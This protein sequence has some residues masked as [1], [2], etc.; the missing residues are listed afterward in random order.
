MPLIRKDLASLAGSFPRP[1]ECLQPTTF[2]DFGDSRVH[3]RTTLWV[4]DREDAREK[5]VALYLRIRDSYRYDPY[6]ISL[7]PADYRAS[8]LVGLDRTFCVPKAIL[9]AAMA[10]SAGV[11]AA[12]GFADVKNHLATERLLTTMRTDVFAFHGY[13]A[14]FIDGYWVKATPT[15][16]REL[17]AV[18]GVPPL[19]F[20]G[21][22][23]ALLQ[24][25]DG[26]GR[27]HMEYVTDHGLF[28]DF[29][30]DRMIESW[31]STYPHFFD[32]EGGARR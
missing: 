19:E 29:P 3:E 30:F 28:T 15:F 4:A 32:E 16:N 7:D 1:E 11:P 12:L 31:R 8:A 27:R 25:F 17:C 13:V 10:R 26:D 6:R 21:R 2:L 9:L 14:L 20:D 24:P 22:S 23:D 5:A 18:F